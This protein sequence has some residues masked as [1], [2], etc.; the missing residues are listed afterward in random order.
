[1][2]KRR[3]ERLGVRE[4]YYR[5][6]ETYDAPPNPVVALDEIVIFEPV[7]GGRS[8]WLASDAPAR[9]FDPF[10]RRI[11]LAR[12]DTAQ[13]QFGV[14]ARAPARGLGQRRGNRGRVNR[15]VAGR[16][17]GGIHHAETAPVTCSDR[18][19]NIAHPRRVLSCARG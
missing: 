10:A 13:V 11:A 12:T 8:A 17:R 2:T 4:G 18:S 3:I 6:S 5:W 14:P 16:G 7:G 15:V 19:R 9:S 1:M